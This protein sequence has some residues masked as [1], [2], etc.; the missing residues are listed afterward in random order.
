VSAKARSRPD[1]SLYEAGQ[2]EHGSFG[3]VVLGGSD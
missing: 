3:F 2:L 1:G